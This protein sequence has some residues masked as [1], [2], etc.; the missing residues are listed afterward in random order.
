M[1]EIPLPRLEHYHTNILSEIKTLE[2]T[3][4]SW[5][6]SEQQAEYRQILEAGRAA[7]KA[8]ES[9]I[10][11]RSAGHLNDLVQRIGQPQMKEVTTRPTV[12]SQEGKIIHDR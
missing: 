1:N 3:M 10:A 6:D 4:L 2:S 5:R 12:Q 8:V 7:L 11:R 9:E